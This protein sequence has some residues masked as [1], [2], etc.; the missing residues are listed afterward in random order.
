MK[1]TE[2]LKEEHKIIKEMLNILE[3]IIKKIENNEEVEKEH[4]NQIIDFIKNFA[5]K[6]HHGKEEDLLFKTMLNKGFPEGGPITVMLIEHET[7]REYVKKL[8]KGI[9]DN[10]KKEIIE[11]GKNYISLLREHIEKEDNILYEIAKGVLDNEED[12]K[13][14]NEF[15]KFE[16]E[17]IGIGL[18][19]KYHQIIDGLNKIY[20]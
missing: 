14:I 16:K 4:L 15:E 2:I 7:G 11:N 13:L 1:A 8:D 19:E 20:K 12:K 10:N 9:Q 6:C 3:I 5:D 18:H 17:I